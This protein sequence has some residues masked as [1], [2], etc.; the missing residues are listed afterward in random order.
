LQYL[1]DEGG[2]VLPTRPARLEFFIPR[3]RQGFLKDVAERIVSFSA[4]LP[5]VDSCA[6]HDV[7]DLTPQ[8]FAAALSRVDLATRGVGVVAVDH[9]LTRQAV[10]DLVEAGVKVVTLASDLLETPRSAYVGLDDRVAGR[11]AAHVMGSFARGRTG[12]VAMFVSQRAFL[13]QRERELG[14]VTLIGQEFPKLRVLPAID[15]MGDS[16][17]GEAV[18]RDL[19]ASDPDLLGIYS[20]GGARTGIARAL[21]GVERARRPFVIVHDLSDV[22]IR[23]LASDQIDLVI[24]QNARLVAEQAVIRLLGAV[25]ATNIYL[26]EH[27][28]EPRL[29]FR[30]NIPR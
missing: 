19:L 1:P 29:I 28:I 2:T 7:S 11:T 23:A 16:D 26:P 4:K 27:F 13:G 30:E 3:T 15:L 25:A 22:T 6:V 18:T 17:Q 24:D 20:M 10:R 14:F 12:T 21:S 9:P 8:T 5:L